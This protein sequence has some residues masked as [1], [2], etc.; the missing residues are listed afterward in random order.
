MSKSS[1]K[2]TS[3]KSGRE[4]AHFVPLGVIRKDYN[5][6]LAMYMKRQKAQDV[7]VTMPVEMQVGT[8]GRQ[9]FFVAVA[10]TSRFGESESLADEVQRMAPEGHMPL[11]AW[12]PANLYGSNDFGI[13]IDEVPIGENLKN[14]LV[15]EVINQAAIEATV[16]ARSKLG[17]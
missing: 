16:I 4:P 8:K 2:S 5:S 10:V 1:Q 9:K 13:F 3:A 6:N 11:F 7:V 14:G 12:V 17:K 15:A